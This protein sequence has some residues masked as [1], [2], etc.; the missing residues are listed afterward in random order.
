MWRALLPLLL[1]HFY[2]PH[3]GAFRCCHLYPAISLRAH[4]G[5]SPE[6]RGGG[7]EPGREA[8][9]GGGGISLV[10]GARLSTTGG[11]RPAWV[12]VLGREGGQRSQAVAFPSDPV[13]SPAASRQGREMK[14][15]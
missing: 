11:T 9:R 15:E 2:S 10:A 14:Q 3:A 8:A 5:R 1:F 7:R 4:R 12:R 13:K 6:P